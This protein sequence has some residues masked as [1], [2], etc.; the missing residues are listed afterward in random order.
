MDMHSWGPSNTWTQP[1]KTGLPLA[2]VNERKQQ[3]DCLESKALFTP[4]V[5]H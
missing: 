1:N 3:N 2:K 5:F 4:A